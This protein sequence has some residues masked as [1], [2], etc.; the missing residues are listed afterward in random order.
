[1]QQ[2]SGSSVSTRISLGNDLLAILPGIA[3]AQI[4]KADFVS[5]RPPAI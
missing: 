4:T 5:I 1:M 2:G 3:K